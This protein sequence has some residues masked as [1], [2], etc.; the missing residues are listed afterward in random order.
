MS[1]QITFF[2]GI[3]VSALTPRQLLARTEY[4]S[5]L[6]NAAAA[7]MNMI[8]CCQSLKRMRDDKLYEE[9]GFETFEQYTISAHNIKQRQA[10]NLISVAENNTPEFLQSNA[11]V[12]I[13]KLIALS[14]LPEEQKEKFVAEHDVEAMSTREVSEEVKHIKE[15]ENKLAAKDEQLEI[16]KAKRQDA[17]SEAEAYKSTKPE[18]NEEEIKIRAKALADKLIK[19]ELEKEIA[20]HKSF[21]DAANER[22]KR[23]ENELEQQKEQSV[24][25]RQT[26]K[27]QLDYAKICREDA[28]KALKDKE[29][30]L[31]GLEE[32]KKQAEQAEADKAALEKK[33]ATYGDPE[34]ARFKLMF[35]EWQKSSVQLLAQLEKLN[36]ET[37]E[38]CKLAMKKAVEGWKL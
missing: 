20:S 27:E 23:L 3:E 4:V 31:T 15:L 10:Y 28:E 33:L 24:S 5:V 17:E 36:A 2:E 6:T 13:T 8:A 7:R 26:F 18:I 37:Q 9:F 11:K 35:E 14:A 38:K 34:L 16:E 25:V 29:E 19:E 30:E 1:N 32:Y 22:A 21:V 12:E